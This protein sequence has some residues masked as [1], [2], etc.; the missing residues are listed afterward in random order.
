M[1]LIVG[2][3]FTVIENE[4]GIPEQLFD[5]GVT[6]INEVTGTFDALTP[7]NDPTVAVPDSGM[8]PVAEVELVQL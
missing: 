2:I 4:V 7:V 8:R 1:P 6:V 5:N 3:G